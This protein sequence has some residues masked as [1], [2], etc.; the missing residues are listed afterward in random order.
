MSQLSTFASS[1]GGGG[2]ITLDGNTGT[3]SGSIVHVVTP[4]SNTT[5]TFSGDNASTLTLNT[6]DSNSNVAYGN[7]ALNALGIIRNASQNVAVGQSA[8]QMIG[9]QAG[10]TGNVAIGYNC[11]SQVNRSTSANN[12]LIGSQVSSGA[13]VG[14]SNILIG[15]N[16]GN[17][18]GGNESN[19]IQLNAQST[20]SIGDE[21]T[22]RIGDGTGAGTQQLNMAFISGINGIS[23]VGSAVLVSG[24]DQLGIAVSSRKYKENI[25]DM[26]D[27]SSNIM[28]LRPVSFTYKT[29]SALQTGLIAEEV[30]E[31]MPNLVVYDKQGDPQTVKYHD[32]PALLLNEI[33][34]LRKEVDELKRSK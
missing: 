26:D 29:D 4:T 14:N 24:S 8:L 30:H 31:I 13:G 27:I 6:T 10:Q 1:G 16:N 22:L 19:N 7:N 3:A 28:K 2:I 18:F 25:Q 15:F 33:Q 5:L 23:V 12:V 21:N 20:S 32:L 9:T 17:N 11:G 34:K